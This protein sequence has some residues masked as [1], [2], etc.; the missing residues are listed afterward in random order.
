MS[1][2]KN[3]K[4]SNAFDPGKN[5]KI[6]RTIE[7]PSA[8]MNMKPAWRFELFDNDSKWGVQGN[9]NY[10]VFE[11]VLSKMKNLEKM[12]WGEIFKNKDYNHDIKVPSL[13]KEAI[14]RLKVLKVDD[15]KLFRLRLT[16]K[17][18]IYGIFQ[19]HILKIIW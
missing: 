17:Q 11:E 16:G 18:R 12:T 2:G 13:C 5:K 15:A 9:Y 7:N 3:K 14:N 1:K 4:P 6:P 8:F 19:G 10:N